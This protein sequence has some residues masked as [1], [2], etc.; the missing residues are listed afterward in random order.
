[1][2]KVYLIALFSTLTLTVIFQAVTNHRLYKRLSEV[3]REVQALHMPFPPLQGR[4][5]LGASVSIDV[6]SSR[7]P[8]L[9]LAFYPA[10]PFCKEN[11]PTWKTLAAKAASKNVH[12]YYV[13]ITPDPVSTQYCTRLG[14]PCEDVLNS[15]SVENILMYRLDR[16][17][18]TEIID[19]KGQLLYQVSGPLDRPAMERLEFYLSMA[20]L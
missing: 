5:P 14:I 15:V 1:M 4:N 6:W 19:R 10:C 13:N 11:W 2:K 9:L 18:I 17:P 12:V 8:A 16:T 20:A 7:Q 3:Q